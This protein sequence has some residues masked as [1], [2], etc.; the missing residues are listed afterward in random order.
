MT[1][2][3]ELLERVRNA[4]GPD[5]E[6]DGDIAQAFEVAPSYLPRIT[7]AGRSWL[8]AEF[9]E[10][11]TWDTWEAP[12]YTASIDAALALVERVLPSWTT[13]VHSGDATAEVC[14]IGFRLVY[15]PA[16]NKSGVELFYQPQW[17]IEPP[18]IG[19]GCG[20]TTPLA[21]VEALLSALIAKEGAK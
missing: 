1:D 3:S 10:P 17:N 15:W 13:D 8:W 7:D 4:K 16:D 21:I 12:E 5:R 9:V 11:D 18:V 2:L 14:P 19:E 6:I 20:A